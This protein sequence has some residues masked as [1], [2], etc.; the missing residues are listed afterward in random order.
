M[1]VIPRTLRAR[2][3]LAF[4]ASV[5][6]ACALLTY[7]FAE[8]YSRLALADQGDALQTL[9]QGTGT[10]FAE[11]LHERLR[12]VDLMAQEPPAGAQ[13]TLDPAAWRPVLERLQK[14]RAHYS[15]IGVVDAQGRVVTATGDLLLGRDVSTR[16][17][18]V[19]GREA[20][21]VGDVHGATLLAALLPPDADGEP[22]RFV[23]FAVPIRDAR[24]NTAGVLGVHARWDWARDVI[25]NLR[26]ARIRDK[27]V[28]VYILD[29]AGQVIHRPQGHPAASPVWEGAPPLVGGAD[30]AWTDGNRYLTAVAKLPARD[31]AAD[32]GWTI[33]VRQPLDLARAASIRARDT[34][35]VIGLAAALLASLLAWAFAARLVRPLDRIAASARR[36]QAGELGLEIPQVDSPRELAQ[37]SAALRDMKESLLEREAALELA[38]HELEDRVDKR[39]AELASV[40]RQLEQA[41]D[42]LRDLAHQ[43]S[44]TGLA[45][46]R[47]AD[48]RLAVEMSRHR[49]SRQCLSLML[50]DIDHFKQVNDTWGHAAGDAVLKAVA[51]ALEDACRAADGVARVG[52][53]E[54]MVLMPET[55]PQGARIVAEKVRKAIAAITD[56]PALVTVSIGLVSHAEGY[57]DAEAVLRDADGALYA[58]KQ[59]GRNRVVVA[60][61]IEATTT[62]SSRSSRTSR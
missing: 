34:S 13:G 20:P 16:P 24:G 5:L 3:A 59:G 37:L 40:H 8:R 2:I 54:F 30:L 15:W 42:E 60:Q 21:H 14:N 57:V 19:A 61:D 39:T 36:I 43:D 29:R 53:E 41:N 44:L 55:L 51:L 7:G 46:R 31:H 48:D 28:L 52:G 58:A 33:V 32:L 27:G 18:Y 12:E 17:W 45:N 1:S 50:I 49:R 38:K 10:V 25:S 56:A 23:D 11:G 22:A 4:G 47:A 26:S 62:A 9:A 35:L 6:L